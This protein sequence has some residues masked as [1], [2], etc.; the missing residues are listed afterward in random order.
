MAATAKTGEAEGKRKRRGREERRTAAEGRLGARGG[1]CGGQVVQRQYC[2]RSPCARA[3]R[4]GL[5]VLPPVYTRVK[6]GSHPEAKPGMN[7]PDPIRP[8]PLQALRYGGEDNARCLE[9]WVQERAHKEMGERDALYGGRTVPRTIV[10]LPCGM[11][12]RAEGP[13]GD[14]RALRADYRRVTMRASGWLHQNTRKGVEPEASQS[15]GGLL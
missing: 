11:P 6:A 3:S 1:L 14:R 10:P 2:E 7:G 4:A 13:I 15:S 8:K 12:G 9:L 5:L